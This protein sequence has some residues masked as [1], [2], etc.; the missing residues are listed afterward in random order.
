MKL[1]EKL[2][3]LLES[4]GYSVQYANA[5]CVEIGRYS[6]AGQ[7]FWFCAD[8]GNDLEAFAENILSE[9]LNFDV[10]YETYL[11]LD[12]TGHGK[13]GAPYDMKEVYEDMEEC[14]EYIREVY[15]IVYDFAA[16][17]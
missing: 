16:E 15:G 4:Y 12:N 5:D 11:W 13:N 6:P 7:D 14:Q 9:Y 8:L 2:I 3:D 1:P 10:S 17:T